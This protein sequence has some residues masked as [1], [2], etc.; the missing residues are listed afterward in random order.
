MAFNDGFARP[1]AKK[2]GASYLTGDMVA[3]DLLSGKTGYSN[4]PNT[5]ITGTMP[6]NA[7]DVAA[8]SSHASGTSIHVVPA[9]GY[10]DGSDDAVV[11]TDA[12]FVAANILNGVDIFGVTGSLTSVPSAAGDVLN[13]EAG[14]FVSSTSTS[15]EK[16]YELTVNGSGT[17]RIQVFLGGSHGT[18]TYYCKVYRNGSAV[19][20]ELSVTPATGSSYSWVT[21]DVAGWSPTD[22]LQVYLKRVS[23]GTT[24]YA[25]G[26][27]VLTTFCPVTYP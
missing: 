12:D 5:K 18:Y 20:A 25:L 2:G 23:G 14:S 7:G 13:Y 17:F 21:D 11:I 10:T 4:D 27:K 16:K 9:T 3:A 1:K 6:N 15:Y 19:G 8:V 24:C 22:K 26:L